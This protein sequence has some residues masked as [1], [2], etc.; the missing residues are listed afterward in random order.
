[1]V[2]MLSASVVD[3]EFEFRYAHTK[4]T[5]HVSLSS[6]NKTRLTRNQDMPTGGLL[7]QRERTIKIQLRLLI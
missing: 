6:T 1:M 3:S 7:F 5:T 4:D 2:S